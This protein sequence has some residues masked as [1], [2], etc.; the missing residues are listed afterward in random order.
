MNK[1]T[2]IDS[3]MTRQPEVKLALQVERNAR[4]AELD[5]DIPS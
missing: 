5:S 4:P 1:D 2:M 3:W